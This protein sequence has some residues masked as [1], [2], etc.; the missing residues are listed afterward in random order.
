MTIEERTYGAD[1]I[2]VMEGLDHV[3][4][5]PGMYIGSTGAAGL[6]HILWEV[7]D[8]AVDEHLGGFGT[9]I[10]VTLLADGGARVRDWGRGMPVDPMS[11]G[12]HKG[13][14]AAEVI[15]TVLNAGGKFDADGGAY[16]TSGG[17]HGVGL[18]AMTALSTRVELCVRRDGR[19]HTQSFTLAH[20]PKGL[21]PGVPSGPLRT[22][23]KSDRSEQGTEITFWPDMSCFTDDQGQPLSG[24]S[25]RTI[26][27]R[28]ENRSYVHPGLTFAFTDE[29]GDGEPFTAEFHSQ[30]GLADLVAKLSSSREPICAPIKI[31]GANPGEKMEV[32]VAL[33]WNAGYAETMIAYSNGVANP[34]GGKHCEGL[35]RA[36]TRAVNRYARDKG[37]LRE[38]DENPTGADVRQGMIAVISLLLSNPSYDSQSKNRL[39]TVQAAGVVESIVYEHLG[40][41]LEEHP[42][43][44]K[45]IAEKAAAAMRERCKTDEDRKAD[46]ALARKNVF[47]GSALPDKLYDCQMTPKEAAQFGGT[48]V[49]LC[50]GDSAGGTLVSARQP[51][52]QAVLPL[53]GKL[54][55]VEGQSASKIV[56]NGVLSQMILT[57][58]AGRGIDF[59]VSKMRYDRVILMSVHG[60]EP[61]LLRDSAGWLRPFSIGEFVDEKIA[62][63]DEVPDFSAVSLSVETASVGEG[64][65]KKVIRHHSDLP[66]FNLTTAYGRSVTVTAGHSV[67]TWEDEAVVLRPSDALRVG[68]VI[69]APRVLPPGANVVEMDI[70][71]LF[72]ASE[73][74]EGLRISGPGVRSVLEDRFIGRSRDAG[75]SRLRLT[76]RFVDEVRASRKQVGLQ[77]KDMAERLGVHVSTYCGFEHPGRSAAALVSVRHVKLICEILGLRWPDDC[78][79]NPSMIQRSHDLAAPA[80]DSRSARDRK[81]GDVMWLKDLHPSEFA[82]IGNASIFVHAHKG[83]ELPRFLPMSEELCEVLGW[84]TAEG[85]AGARGRCSLALGA[86]DDAYLPRIK[87]ALHATF[88]VAPTVIV[89]NG[90]PNSLHLYFDH[91]M[92]ARLLRVVGACDSIAKNK[93]VPALM[94][95]V[96]DSC[97]LAYLRGMYLGDGTKATKMSHIRLVLASTASRGLASDICYLLG[98]LG[99]IAGVH[100]DRPRDSTMRNGRVIKSSGNFHVGVNGVDQIR[101]LRSVWHPSDQAHNIAARLADRRRRGG[102]SGCIQISKDLIGLPIVSISEA[103]HS[104]FVYDLSVADDESFVAGWNGGLMAHN[105][106]AD[107]DGAHIQTLLITFFWRQMGDMIREGRL[108][109]AQPPLYV[110]TS[111]E[112]KVYFANDAAKDAY[113]AANPAAAKQHFLRMKGLG[114]MNAD[115]LSATTLDPATRQLLQVTVDDAIGFDDLM[116]RLMGN[117]SQ[118]RLEW[119][120]ESSLSGTN[121]GGR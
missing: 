64:P 4:K 99:V 87:N 28:L 20:T 6:H 91:G 70:L 25:R 72:H 10:E 35:T 32:G 97:K 27:E 76:Q 94:F 23:G 82:R 44:A 120:L 14:S 17:L 60:D 88:N 38:K 47:K 12:A 54:L 84:F 67:F 21:K 49:V 113:V 63:G 77:S 71:P 31:T 24:W 96:D 16:K 7:V 40:R 95:N 46:K 68:D 66:M 79:V 61:V 36:V 50:E 106:D 92:V 109:I 57:V 108:F 58:G 75:E 69:V 5:R 83:N 90:R 3:R 53:R 9:R 102:P 48:E 104:G 103:P 19:I 18:K 22:A 11:S 2:T 33:G 110:T 118:A 62:L 8:N 85:S 107:P 98:Q 30:N 93:R 112:G 74:G 41:W 56:A 51:A 116:S 78:V 45:R 37:V 119:L 1:D 114:E 42:A 89:P 111:K 80:G 121:M 29:R 105:T 15:L 43:D 13:K 55:N 86:A 59:D 52:T 73:L 100:R 65:L 81:L 34:G 101:L 39:E 117:S 26:T 115:D